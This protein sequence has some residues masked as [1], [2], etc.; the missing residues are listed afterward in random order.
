MRIKQVAIYQPAVRLRVVEI[1]ANKDGTAVDV[2]L[3]VLGVQCEVQS[4]DDE[5]QGDPDETRHR[6][7][8]WSWEG[9]CVDTLHRVRSDHT[10]S[11]FI[12][13]PAYETDWWDDEIERVKG[14]MAAKAKPTV[15]IDDLGL[16]TRLRNCLETGGLRTIGDLCDRTAREL[17]TLRN[18]GDGS[19]HE[20]KERL[21]AHGL[22]LAGS[23]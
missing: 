6:I 23:D 18:F 13:H 15:T 16:S 22:S 14:L 10:D 7:L 12:V 9:G 11:A 8:V 20:L 2:E 1:Y 4:F 5:D 21:A 3:P 17:R 19:L